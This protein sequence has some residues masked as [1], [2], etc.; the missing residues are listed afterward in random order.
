MMGIYI[1]IKRF[2][3]NNVKCNINYFVSCILLFEYLHML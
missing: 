1:G 3:I 2:G